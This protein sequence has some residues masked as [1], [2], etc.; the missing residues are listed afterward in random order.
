MQFY[1]LIG[2]EEG[3]DYFLSASFFTSKTEKLIAL[4]AEYK[5]KCAV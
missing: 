1:G 2:D 4:H 3:K 5:I